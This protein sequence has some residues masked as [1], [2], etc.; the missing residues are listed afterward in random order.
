M[1]LNSANNNLS[2]F[3]EDMKIIFK[4]MKEKHQ[5]LKNVSGNNNNNSQNQKND[6]SSL[7]NK[8]SFLKKFSVGREFDFGYESYVSI[9]GMDFRAVGTHIQFRVRHENELN[10]T[11]PL[12]QLKVFLTLQIKDISFLLN[13]K[14]III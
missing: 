3:F 2:L 4:K 14:Y 9:Q 12:S 8:I 7:K 10:N 6:I 11:S 13:L 5:A 1:E